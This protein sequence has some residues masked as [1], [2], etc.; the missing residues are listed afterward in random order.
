MP[1][2]VKFSEVATSIAIVNDSFSQWFDIQNICDYSAHDNAGLAVV[3]LSRTNE[4]D[5]G[6]FTVKYLILFIIK[7]FP[8]NLK[9]S[10]Q[11]SIKELM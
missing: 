11:F 8:N 5:F 3:I 4:T 6:L 9:P 7:R 1:S 10:F 2:L